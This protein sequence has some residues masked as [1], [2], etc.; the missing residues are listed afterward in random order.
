MSPYLLVP[1]DPQK[2]QIRLVHLQPGR[3]MDEI[4]CK[5]EVVDLGEAER[6]GYNALSYEWGDAEASERVILAGC[7][8]PVRPNLW[9]AMWHL[10]CT[11]AAAIFWID[12]VCIDQENLE[13]KNHQIS[14]I[15]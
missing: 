8:V 11:D 9:W 2:A 10:R 14:T 5:L 13:E 15:R 1:L 7:K 3:D 12:A 4:R 6:I